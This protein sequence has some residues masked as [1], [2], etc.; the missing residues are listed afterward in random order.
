MLRIHSGLV[1][2]ASMSN[3][4]PAIADGVNVLSGDR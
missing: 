4:K 1:T 2:I 3:K